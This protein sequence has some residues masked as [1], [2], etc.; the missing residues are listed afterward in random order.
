MKTRKNKCNHQYVITNPVP[1]NGDR[2][3]RYPGVIVAQMLGEQL[4]TFEL[5]L[6]LTPQDGK[7]T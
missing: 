7:Y 2:P 3:A 1:Y 5:Y 6:R 4:I